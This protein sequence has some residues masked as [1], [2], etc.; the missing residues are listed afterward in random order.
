MAPRPNSG[1]EPLHRKPG[2]VTAAQTL[3]WIQFSFL[4]CCGFGT[5]F[6]TL[7]LTGV[8]EDLGF[9]E[10]PLEGVENLMV[11]AAAV[12]AG[13]AAAAILFGVLAAKI[14]AG[15]RSAQVMTIVL[16][17]GIIVFGFVG[18][19]TRFEVEDYAGTPVDGSEAVGTLLALVLPILTLVCLCT[20][21]ANQWFRQGGRDAWPRYAAHPPVA[22]Y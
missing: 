18:L 8:V 15:R 17:L 20:G 9:R 4:L 3:M 5:T 2:T 22:P 6:A 1:P 7:F 19:Y 10:D 13:V 21:S 16:M 14:G 12:V 11:L